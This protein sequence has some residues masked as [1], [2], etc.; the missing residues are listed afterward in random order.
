MAF[1]IFHPVPN[2]AHWFLVTGASEALATIGEHFHFNF[3][4]IPVDRLLT[5]FETPDAPS[6]ACSLVLEPRAVVGG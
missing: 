3:D 2:A 1:E 5:R 4:I 6:L